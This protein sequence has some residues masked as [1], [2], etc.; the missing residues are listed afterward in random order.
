MLTLPF[1]EPNS[2]QTSRTFRTSW[3]TNQLVKTVKP[4]P[5]GDT[6]DTTHE[7][8][9]G[10]D[11][12]E[13]DGV[14][15]V[16]LRRRAS[17]KSKLSQDR[18][19][20]VRVRRIEANTRER[21]RMHGLNNALDSLRKVV[22][23]YSKTQKLSKI[24]TLRLA[25]N[26]IWALGEILSS[27]RRPDLL[28]FVQTL[29]KGLSQP[30]TNLVASCLQLNA[31]SFV[32]EPGGDSFPLY[33]AYHHHGAE[34]LGSSSRSLRPFGSFCGP[35]E[36]LQDSPSPQSPGPLEARGLSPPINFNGIFS[37][38]HEDPGDYR[39]CHRGLCYQGASAHLGPYDI[40]LRG[41]FYQVQ[42]E[43]NKPFH[44]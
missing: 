20:R 33:P 28:T 26:Y 21:N 39:S 19:D 8:R 23:C 37:L 5:G 18:L 11:N 12:E 15:G 3:A 30:T 14:G 27:G 29:C 9:D 32:S 40:H 24:E 2:N 43:L 44:N 31:R 13:E 16:P 22:P 6:T 41:Q 42:E 1:D 38:K 17:H 4:E 34:G 10:A 25:R 35:Y 36:A 7:E